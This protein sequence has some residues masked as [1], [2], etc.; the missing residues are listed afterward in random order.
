MAPSLPRLQA[1]ERREVARLSKVLGVKPEATV[2]CIVPTYRRPETLVQAVNSIL[3]QEFQNFVVIVVDDGGGL[4]PL[5]Q[6]SRVFSVSL[7]RNSA[8][9]GVVR[10]I[11]IRLTSSKYVAFLD[12]DNTWTPKHLSLCVRELENGADFVYTAIRRI[13]SDGVELDR[14]SREFDRHALADEHNYIDANSIVLRRSAKTL[15][16]R[17]PRVKSTFPKEDWEFA[18]R[19]TQRGNVRHIPEATVEYLVNADSYFTEWIL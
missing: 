18:F 2:A 19:H 12:D 8:V 10:N 9:L 5:P 4:P 7:S 14:I 16:S 11:G 3:Q 6:D 15:F 13:R 17:L 1:L